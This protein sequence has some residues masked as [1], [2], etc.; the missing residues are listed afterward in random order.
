MEQVELIIRFDTCTKTNYKGRD[1]YI[2]GNNGGFSNSKTNSE[3]R[4]YS[5]KFDQLNLQY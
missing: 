4:N 2:Y 5:G 3:N 1:S